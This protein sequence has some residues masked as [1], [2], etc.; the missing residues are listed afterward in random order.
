[1]AEAGKLLSLGD[2]Q[3]EAEPLRGIE[4]S[5]AGGCAGVHQEGEEQVD[6]DQQARGDDDPRDAVTPGHDEREPED[7]SRGH[8]PCDDGPRV[9]DEVRGLVGGLQ[10]PLVRGARPGDPAGVP[11][12]HLQHR[13]LLE[14]RAV[15]RPLASGS[16]PGNVGREALQPPSFG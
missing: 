10:R 4:Q 15:Q 11:A 16:I 12:L 5:S 2:A 3:I 8:H 1:V 6:A 9:G 13:S 14:Q 7:E